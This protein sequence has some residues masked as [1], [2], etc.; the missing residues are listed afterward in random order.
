MLPWTIRLEMVASAH[1]EIRLVLDRSRELADLREERRRGAALRTQLVDEQA[2][3]TRRREEAIE[4][5]VERAGARSLL[6]RRARIAEARARAEQWQDQETRSS[7][8]LLRERL[9]DIERELARLDD[10]LAPLERDPALQDE[11]LLD[12]LTML[13]GTIA[14]TVDRDEARGDRVRAPWRRRRDEADAVATR[15][16]QLVRAEALV[17]D[18]AFANGP[19]HLVG[20]RGLAV[21]EVRHGHDRGGVLDD[22]S[23][24]SLRRIATEAAAKAG[25]DTALTVVCLTGAVGP[26]RVADGV[27]VCR[28]AGLEDVLRARPDTPVG[29]AGLAR[30][31]EALRTLPLPLVDVPA[32]PPLTHLLPVQ[33]ADVPG[34]MPALRRLVTAAH[35]EARSA[36]ARAAPTPAGWS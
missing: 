13:S 9:D 20:D 28:P 36:A 5:A 1:R 7:R 17:T 24:Q 27:H 8:R 19:I 12:W 35:A 3:L 32:P 18:V 22:G 21:V 15:L 26:D 10:E 30:A 16:H 34:A 25:V 31:A 2:A 29:A 33:V 11:L 23:T 6:R 14:A 4:Q